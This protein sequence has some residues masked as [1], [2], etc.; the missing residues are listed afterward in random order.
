MKKLID[1]LESLIKKLA[2][3][4]VATGDE[5]TSCCMLKNPE[6][7]ATAILELIERMANLKH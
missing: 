2:I 4:D 5:G 6:D 3:C 7:L 1:E